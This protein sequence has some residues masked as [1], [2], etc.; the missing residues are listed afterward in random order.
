MWMADSGGSHSL[1]SAG[2][3]VCLSVCPLACLIRI[4]LPLVFK[5]M[6]TRTFSLSDSED[7]RS[8][9]RSGRDTA[10]FIDDE[11]KKEE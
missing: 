3:D 7:S 10:A 8:P 5:N 4:P 2:K 6:L 1:R 11:E 9:V